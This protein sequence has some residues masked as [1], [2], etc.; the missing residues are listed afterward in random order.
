MGAYPAVGAADWGPDG[1]L[2]CGPDGR[3]AGAADCGAA[4]CGPDG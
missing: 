2:D 4:D 3:L 1:Y